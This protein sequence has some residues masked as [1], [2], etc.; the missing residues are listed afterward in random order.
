MGLLFMA[1]IKIIG[2]YKITSPSGKIYI[3]QSR[4][5]DKRLKSYKCGSSKTKGQPKLYNSFEKYG[6]DNCIK[7]S[8]KYSAFNQLIYTNAK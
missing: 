4:D 1:R 5:L 6:I 2:I 7:Q 8:A 3:G